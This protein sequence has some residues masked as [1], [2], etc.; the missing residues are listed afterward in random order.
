[1]EVTC[2]LRA[3]AINKKGLAPIQITFCWDANRIRLGSKVSCRPADWN[4]KLEKV[5]DRPG[6][7]AAQVNAVL[8]RWERAGT[9]AHSDARAAGERWDE[10]RM[11]AEIRVRYQRLLDEANGRPVTPVAG[12][13]TGKQAPHLLRVHA[14]VAGV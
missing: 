2:Q 7:Y 13:P 10:E 9:S 11:E 5:K 12:R 3:T 4:E 8:E 6:T 1:M 14:A